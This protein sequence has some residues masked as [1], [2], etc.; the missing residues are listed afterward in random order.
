[1][2]FLVVVRPELLEERASLLRKFARI[3]R[4]LASPETVEIYRDPYA[5][6]EESASI[7]VNGNPKD[8]VSLRV[9]S[10]LLSVRISRVRAEKVSET[11]V[12]EWLMRLPNVRWACYHERNCHLGD[13]TPSQLDGYFHLAECPCSNHSDCREV[14]CGDCLGGCPKTIHCGECDS[15]WLEGET[16]TKSP[17]VY[18]PIEV[19]KEEMLS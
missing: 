17:M 2:M 13:H 5:G 4:T 18:G 7:G 19:L 9:L 10:D 1:M 15:H 11:E 16:P 3:V 14:P 6:L 12:L 8:I